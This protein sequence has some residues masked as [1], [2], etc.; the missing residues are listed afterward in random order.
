MLITIILNKIT[1]K[2][3]KK[4]I[5]MKWNHWNWKKFSKM[6]IRKNPKFSNGTELTNIDEI[7]MRIFDNF[8][9]LLFCLDKA[10]F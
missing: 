2:K 10:I 7:H 1:M 5:E 4:I 3:C 9:Q 6:L 8:E